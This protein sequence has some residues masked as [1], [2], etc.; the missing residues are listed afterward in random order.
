VPQKIKLALIQN[1]MRLFLLIFII[2]FLFIAC[3]SAQA[4]ENHKQL[5]GQT[6]IGLNCE[7]QRLEEKGILV[8]K[9][10][11]KTQKLYN[12]HSN[13]F[14]IQGATP[15]YYYFSENKAC[16]IT[17][18]SA[19]QAKGLK[20]SDVLMAIKSGY[21]AIRQAYI[22]VE[23]RYMFSIPNGRYETFFYC[24]ERRNQEK[25]IATESYADLKDRFIFKEIF[26]KGNLQELNSTVLAYSLILQQSH[27]SST[28]PSGTE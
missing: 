1:H 3:K 11:R 26:G 12:R 9:V 10:E 8:E 28:E 25:E 13:N 17:G 15:Y 19:T 27:N 5:E 7:N 21:H 16:T 23:Y 2:P 18:Y 22:K 20:N 24:G 4:K 14:L 6:K